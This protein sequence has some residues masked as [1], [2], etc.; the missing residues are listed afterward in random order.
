MMGGDNYKK[1]PHINMGKSKKYTI[2]FVTIVFFT[3]P[4]SVLFLQFI[5]SSI[6][7]YSALYT[8]LP[9]SSN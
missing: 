9:N 7:S 8:K 4:Y 1:T 2:S 3:F 6:N 5:L